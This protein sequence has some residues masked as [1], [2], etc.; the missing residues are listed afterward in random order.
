V[1][2]SQDE[3]SE[4]ERLSSLAVGFFHVMTLATASDRDSDM[5]GMLSSMLA[6]ISPALM[7]DART[8]AHALSRQG[9]RR[10]CGLS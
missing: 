9:S 1:P 7:M 6:D 10:T 5:V 2:L 3:R 8:V 4:V